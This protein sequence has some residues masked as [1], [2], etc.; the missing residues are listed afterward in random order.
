MKK[1]EKTVQVA[2]V[3]AGAS[4]LMAAVRAAQSMKQAG[5]L[6]SVLVL[7]GCA[8]PGRK[9]LATGNGKCNLTNMNAGPGAYF[10]SAGVQRVL[11][12]VPPARVRA[13]F[14]SLGLLTRADSEGRVYP[15]NEQASAVLGCLLNACEELGVEILCGTAVTSVCRKE[16][17]FSLGLFNGEERLARR[18]ILACGGKAAPSLG[19]GDN[20][21]GL[22]RSLGHMV[23]PRAPALVRLLAPEVPAALKGVRVRACARLLQNGTLTG[24]TR[25][26]VI[27]GAGS[28]SGICI[29]QLARQVS[30]GKE[31][32]A[33]LW[34]DLLPEMEE[35]ELCAFLAQLCREHPELPAEKLLDGVLSAR[36]AGEVLG[37]SGIQGGTCGRV[38]PSQRKAA[39]RH[40]KAFGLRVTGTG[41]WADAQVTAGGVPLKELEL[42]RMASRCC[43]GLYVTGE[44][45]DVDGDCGGYN[46]HWAWATGLLAGD[47]AAHG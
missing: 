25:G 39:A 42:P 37:R 7:E 10:G 1:A 45:C 2:V 8:R 32:E 29:M 35:E 18:V 44:L 38:T 15:V 24:E 19:C 23:T 33:Q 30:C 40:C 46:L 43:P 5:R 47:A 9:L 12:A 41:G 26:E 16:N 28:V 34:L 13:V 14:H 36:L 21:P 11:Q 6:V 4:G 31:K 20:A 27:F 3:G 22:V 17:G